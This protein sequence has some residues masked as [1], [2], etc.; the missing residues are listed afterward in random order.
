MTHSMT[1]FE[2]KTLIELV[3]EYTEN[4]ILQR[5]DMIE[6]N[7]IVLRAC[8][9]ILADIDGPYPIEKTEQNEQ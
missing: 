6:I 7:K 8:R 5:E 1:S 3:R 4:D 9:R 2:K